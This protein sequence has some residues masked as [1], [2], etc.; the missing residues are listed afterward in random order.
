[1]YTIIITK[2]ALDT[3]LDLKHKRVFSTED[4]NSTL[5]PDVLLLRHYPNAT[6]L[7]NGKFWGN[8]K[9]KGGVPISNGFK[10]KW[11]N[12]GSGQIQLRLCVAMVSSQAILCQGYVKHNEKEDKLQIAIFALY[13]DYI[14][15]KKHQEVGKL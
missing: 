3:Y 15:K 4:F 10:M 11:H 7:K 8:A 12:L 5:K 1:M 2:W 9:V 14:L 13:M 6:K